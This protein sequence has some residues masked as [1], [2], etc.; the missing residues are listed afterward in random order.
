V[1][2]IVPSLAEPGRQNLVPICS[3]TVVAPTKILTAA[4]CV[5]VPNI[6]GVS[7]KG[8]GIIANS[9]E[10]PLESGAI[11]TSFVAARRVHVPPGVKVTD[12]RLQRD[13]AILELTDSVSAPSVTILGQ[14]A[15]PLTTVATP[16]VDEVAF[17]YGFGIT[18]VDAES[19]DF[20]ELVAGAMSISAVE[21][22]NVRAVYTDDSSNVC[23]GDSGG[24]LIVQRPSGPVIAG[25][26]SQGSDPG[27]SI[28]D[29]TTFTNLSNS[30]LRRWIGEKL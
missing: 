9:N 14:G 16:Q 3:G 24:P 8:Y 21:E 20:R 23:N 1:V 11:A 18:E 12:G 19:A 4:H 5:T 29:E 7:I 17:I 2:A 6:S 30:F 22:E 26:V 15:A 27:C 10:E 13:V 25:V 28:G